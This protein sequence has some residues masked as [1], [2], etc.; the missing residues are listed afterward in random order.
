MEY[1]WLEFSDRLSQN[2][3]VCQMFV[4]NAK[5]LVVESFVNTDTLN[6]LLH[7]LKEERG[8]A[9]LIQALQYCFT[10]EVA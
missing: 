4:Q 2:V 8:R 6:H 3:A 10:T 7:R 5:D 1:R 9:P